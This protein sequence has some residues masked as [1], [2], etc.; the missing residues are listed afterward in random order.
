MC[1]SC[2]SYTYEDLETVKRIIHG[3]PKQEEL[4]M[5]T[6]LCLLWFAAGFLAASAL[7]AVT[8]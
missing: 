1:L 2:E 4:K 6:T 8:L 7:F 5:D 3:V